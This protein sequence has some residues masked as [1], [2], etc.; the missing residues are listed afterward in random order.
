M[1]ASASE[2][3]AL[4]IYDKVVDVYEKI[5]LLY[6]KFLQFVESCSLPSNNSTA[7]ICEMHLKPYCLQQLG[8]FGVIV[9]M[10]IVVSPGRSRE[11]ET[12]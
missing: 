1:V 2:G 5:F 9:V 10:V 7:T 12:Y 4:E 3:R 11:S 6:T 8:N